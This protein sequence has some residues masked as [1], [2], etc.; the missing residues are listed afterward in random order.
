MVKTLSALVLVVGVV[1]F[2][3]RAGFSEAA[4]DSGKKINL[5]SA[6]TGNFRMRSADMVGQVINADLKSG[7]KMRVALHSG[8][9]MCCKAIGSYPDCVVDAG[10]KIHRLQA[11]R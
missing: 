7:R 3:Q 1:L 10:M 4:A 6:Q 11:I 9:E 5:T 8:E 2:V